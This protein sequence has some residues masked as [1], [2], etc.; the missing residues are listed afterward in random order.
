MDRVYA[1]SVAASLPA[2]A[3]ILRGFPQGDAARPD[4]TPTSPGPEFFNWLTESIRTVIVAGGITPDG[5]DHTQLLR[6]VEALA[7]E[8]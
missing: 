2:S 5:N 4:V 8:S 6:A 3:T 7:A 1:S